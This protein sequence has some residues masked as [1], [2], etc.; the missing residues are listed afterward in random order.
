MICTINILLIGNYLHLSRCPNIQWKKESKYFKS[1]RIYLVGT[2]KN[3]NIAITED[4]LTISGGSLSEYLGSN[5]NNYT[6]K[7][8][9]KGFRKLEEALGVSII[10]GIITRLDIGGNLLV[11]RKPSYF[12][13]L[14]GVFNGLNRFINS[15]TLY[16]S[17]DSLKITFYDKKEQ[18][19]KLNIKLWGKENCIRYENSFKKYQLMKISKEL[20]LQ[21]LT[22][23]DLENSIVYMHLIN[24]WR[25]NYYKIQKIEKYDLELINI[26]NPK[27]F[28][29]AM[30]NFSIANLGGPIEL[31]RMIETIGNEVINS[32]QKTRIKQMIVKKSNSE[33][34]K[35]KNRLIAELDD[36]INEF[37]EFQ[38]AQI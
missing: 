34:N 23:R 38:L 24:K 13:P 28:L 11:S 4:K 29:C 33:I 15:N 8:I 1:E 26:S 12:Y 7:E 37:T 5:T 36:K 16:Y 14:L 21:F 6:K 27:E 9:I 17:S 30:L 3:Y 20:N 22:I 35:V 32:V 25:S 18:A 31:Q 2:H 10:D 19:D